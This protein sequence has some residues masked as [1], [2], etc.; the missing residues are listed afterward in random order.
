VSVAARVCVTSKTPAPRNDR[1]RE[2]PPDTLTAVVSLAVSKPFISI[3][4]VI[5]TRPETAGLPYDTNFLC[6]WLMYPGVLM[7]PLTCDTKFVRL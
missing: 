4:D 2:C 5:Y 3:R 6:S 1:S 7:Y